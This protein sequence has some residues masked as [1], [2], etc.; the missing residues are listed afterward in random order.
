M[1]QHVLQNVIDEVLEGSGTVAQAE[2]HY[3]ALIV[4]SGGDEGGLPLITFLDA[5]QVVGT[6]KVQFGEVV[7]YGEVVEA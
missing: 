1:A 3:E 6:A 2:G 7:G 5:H 4:T